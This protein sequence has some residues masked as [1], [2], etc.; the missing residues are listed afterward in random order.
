MLETFV[1]AQLRP[2][3]T[4]AECEPRLYHL[5]TEAGRHEVDVVAELGAGRIIGIEIKAT[6]A[7]TIEDA[8]HLRW[9]RTELGDRFVSGVVLHT[10]PRLY[11][12]ADGS[13]NAP[14]SWGAERSG[15]SRT[16]RRESSQTCG[17]SHVF[18]ICAWALI[19][20]GLVLGEVGAETARA[21]LLLGAGLMPIGSAGANLGASGA[22]GSAGPKPAV[23]NGVA[24]FIGVVCLAGAT[25]SLM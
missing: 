15:A 9:L 5:R 2:E 7:P 23:I 4:V 10:G 25:A 6:A 12:L 24:G 8:K 16:G 1:A 13:P 14:M 19:V 18:F 22:R 21:A 11:E 20:G 17:S 3:T